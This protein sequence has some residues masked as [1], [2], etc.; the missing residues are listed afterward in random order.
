MKKQISMRILAAVLI[1]FAI[2]ARAGQ[3][4]VSRAPGK[5]SGLFGGAPTAGTVS[6]A[7]LL[8]PDD[9][10]RVSLVARDGNTL[11]A[12]FTP[13]PSHYLYRERIHFTLD[14]SPGVA[15]TSVVLPAGETKN[16]PTFGE[17]R[18]FHK[19]FE[20]VLSLKRDAGA[21]RQIHVKASYQGCNEKAGVC[22]PPIK[23]SFTVNLAAATPPGAGA[24]A[25]NPADKNGGSPQAMAGE[26][27]DDVA[28]ALQSGRFWLI[29]GVFFAAGLALAFTPCVLPMIHIL[30]GIIAGQGASVTRRRG[31]LLAAAYV[32]GMAITYTL[33]GVA[34][35][36]SG[37]LLS[38]ALQNALVL[39]GFAFVFVLLAVSMFGFY[40]LRLPAFLQNRANT[41]SNR[42]PGGRFLAV[43]AM[44][45]LSA[46]IVSPCVAAPLAGALLYIGQ[47]R[48]VALGGSA[49]FALALG[50]GVPL[51]AV[52]FSA[53]TLLP[54]AGPWME[55]VK[56]F[57]GVVLLAVAIW[58]VSPVLPMLVQ[59]L[60]WAALFI[61]SGIFL[62]AV[63]SLPPQA[64]GF[65]RLWKGVGIISLVAGVAL[66]VGALSGSRD[67]LQPL[68]GLRG[69]DQAG[70][71]GLQFEPV[72]SVEDLN[73][74]LKETDRPVMLD[75]YADWCVSCKEMERLTYA[76]PRVQARLG[77]MLILQADVTENNA[78]DQ[79]LLKRFGLYGPPG[80][81][82]FDANGNELRRL[83]V[84][85]YRSP[86]AFLPVL[87]RVLN[88]D[89]SAKST[90]T[91]IDPKAGDH[92]VRIARE[93]A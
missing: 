17:T 28:S 85:G 92:P 42:L 82:F 78:Q 38:S 6:D 73:Q 2:V 1:V 76:D 10:F 93:P 20:A 40:D 14:D 90:L 4:D 21:P 72:R 9:A 29:I 66:L 25:I 52:G 27:S 30:S 69:V 59:M 70:D 41:L 32:M 81:I 31:F 12:R 19:P 68:A 11:V 62:R 79:A 53:G 36:L 84:V 48:D 15:I 88:E 54:K 13:A 8:E 89:P 47:S 43:F 46:L 7:D 26:E 23:K 65:T 39:G 63:D 71:A 87:D 86:E 83:R 77:D 58:I 22:Y 3:D 34:A 16:D 33:A 5:E 55:A 45:A 67:L 35:G 75:F 74:R 24:G 49:L 51:L 44:G 18:V 37:S 61:I 60:A 64:S 50:M 91:R 56:R 80:I 57:F